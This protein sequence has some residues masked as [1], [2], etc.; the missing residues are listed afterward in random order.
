MS[1]RRF[2]THFLRIALV[3]PLFALVSCDDETLPD[4][5]SFYMEMSS[6][7]NPLDKAKELH[8]ETSGLTY[9]VYSDP[10]VP[11][12]NVTSVEAVRVASGHLALR[13]YFDGDGNKM[14]F[15]KSA[16]NIGRMIVT[17]VNGQA[18]GARQVEAPIQGGVFYTFTE[19]SEEELLVL[20]AKMQDSLVKLNRRKN[21]EGF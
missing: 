10:I 18:I 13:F 9:F 12:W 14:L 20:V 16:T 4:L 6:S 8:L 3:L 2:F 5:P 7:Y 17:V 19:L 1:K 11:P 21:E 15:R